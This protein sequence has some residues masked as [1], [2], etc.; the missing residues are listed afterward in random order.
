M[1]WASTTTIAAIGVCAGWLVA[2]VSV[3]RADQ[4]LLVQGSSAHASY[5]RLA[6]RMTEVLGEPVRLVMTE[7]VLEHWEQ[8]RDGGGDV[9]LDEAHFADYRVQKFGFR[10]IAKRS[11]RYA[12]C[13]VVRAGARVLE[14]ED[15]WARTVASRPAPSLLAV[16]LL[17]LFP[18][19]ARAP[20]LVSV[21][22]D[23]EAIRQVLD[24][25]VGAAM[26]PVELAAAHPNLEV[27]LATEEL[28]RMA[29]SL[30]PEVDDAM[31]NALSALLLGTEPRRSRHTPGPVPALPAAVPPAPGFEAADDQLYAGYARLLRGTWGY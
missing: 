19:P 15:L 2:A 1:G 28:P 9:V 30:S 17:E 7:H 27:V 31:A 13:V 23:D 20:R 4:T 6:E 3:A 16:K 8:V 12:F 11:G 5:A 22:S 24:G 21:R 18:D 14:P 26:V 29:L 10:I 25:R